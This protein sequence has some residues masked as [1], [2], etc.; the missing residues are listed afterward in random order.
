[1]TTT[2]N[3][4][5]ICAG[6]PTIRVSDNRGEVVRI[7]RYN[8]TVRDGTLDEQINRSLVSDDGSVSSLWDPR[9]FTLWQS[10]AEQPPNTS[11]HA[12]LSGRS[13]R[14]DSV[15]AGWQVALYDVEGHITW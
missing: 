12:S 5:A 14:T 4:A 9:L 11:T 6:T 1:M 15:D 3:T 2:D 10:N 13:L 7:M 8:R